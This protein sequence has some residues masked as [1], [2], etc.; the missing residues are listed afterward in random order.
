MNLKS[1]L[2]K[3]GFNI[4]DAYEIKEV[5]G[6]VNAD[7][8]EKQLNIESGY[9]WNETQ[10]YI[11]V[12]LNVLNNAKYGDKSFTKTDE[13]KKTMSNS[14]KEAWKD[15]KWSD[16]DYSFFDTKE[17]RDKMSKAT[18]GFKNGNSKLTEE[19]VKYILKY[20]YKPNYPQGKIPK[21][22]LSSSDLANMFN[23]ST[24][25]IREAYKKYS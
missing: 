5:I 15:G 3:Q 6:I 14:C 17:Y 4:D 19:N 25:A 12:L 2:K 7:K 11:R 8:L 10:S 18:S 16:K 22:K 21:N 23:V 13:Y 24:K 20:Y 9:K 1:R